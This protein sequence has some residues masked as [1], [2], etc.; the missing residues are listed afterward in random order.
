MIRKFFKKTPRKKG[1][2]A[3]DIG[4]EV[5]KA[6]L[7]T[8]EEKRNHSG[9]IIQK[10]AIIKGSAAINQ[11]KKNQKSSITDINRIIESAKEAIEL[12]SD[13]AKISPQQLIMGVGGELVRGSTSTIAHK[14]EDPESKINITELR[15]IIHKIQWKAFAEVRKNLS[16]ETGYS[17]IDIK[18][19]NSFIVEI[20]IDGYKV[21]NPLGF[22]GKEIKIS[23]FNSFTP[24]GHHEALQV[25][26]KKLKL[27]LIDIVSEPFALSR[28]LNFNEEEISA[29]FIDI[30]GGGTDIAIAV[31]NSIID[32][33]MFG[34][35]GRTFT[36]RLSVELN[37]SF[38]EADQLKKAYVNEELEQKSKKI[39][40]RI[41]EEDVE[42]WLQGVVLTISEFKKINPLP[43]RILLS[44]GGSYL[45]EI[46]KC[47]NEKNGIKN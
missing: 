15:N 16:E 38:S 39:I 10:R 29:I 1:I 11:S 44:G 28:C 46:K 25:I 37:I 14:R 4:T 6:T 40:S 23:I 22:Q 8:I 21:S 42:I 24:S 18:L 19:I 9:E 27:S 20:R 7:F 36:K 17:E 2:I 34:I 13:Q 12:A 43:S 30:G 5:T 31:N 26:A 47:L 33:K 41:I 45:P 32:T 3:L 35:G